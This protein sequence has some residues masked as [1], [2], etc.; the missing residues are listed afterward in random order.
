MASKFFNNLGGNTLFNKF[1]GIAEGMGLN[2]HQFLAV[3]GYFRSS[4]YFKLRAELKDVKKIQILVGINLDNVFRKQK[5]AGLL[6]LTDPKE[7]TKQYTAEFVNDVREA[8]Y[9]KEIEDGILQLCDDLAAGRVEMRIHPTRN[10]HAKFYLCLPEEHSEN[11]DG[12]VIMGSSNISDSGLGTTKTGDQRY[13]LNVAMKEYDDVHYCHEEFLKLWDEGQPIKPTDIDQARK[14]THLGLDPTP[15]QLYMKVLIDAFGEQAEDNFSMAL[16]VG[17]KELK[18][19][20]DAVI[21]GYQMLLRH[22]GFFLADVVGLGKT[23]VAAMIA[24]RFVEANGKQTSILVIYPPAVERNWKDTFREFGLRNRAQFV[25]NGSLSK[26]IEGAGNYRS[27]EEFDLV[28]VDESHNFRNSEND[29][30]DELQRITKAPRQNPG[31]I[32]GSRKKVI[33]ISATAL[34]NDPSDL[35]DQIL[36]FQDARKSTIPELPSLQNYFAPHIAAYKKIMA[37]RKKNPEADVSGVD[38]IYAAIQQDV[39]QKLTVRRTRRNILNDPDYKADLDS[40][41]IVF[42]KITPPSVLKYAMDKSLGELFWDTHAKLTKVMSYARYRAIEF[43]DPEYAKGRFGNAK[44]VAATLAEIYRVH[45][46]K[47]LESSFAAFKGSLKTF[48]R[49]TEDMIKMFKVDKVL[50]IPELNVRELQAKGMEIDAIITYALE[51]LGCEEKDISFPAKA[52]AEGF[53]PMLED[54]L[55]VLMEMEKEWDEVGDDPK[56]DLFIDQLKGPLFNT[57]VNKSGKLVVFSESVDT[58]DYL[59]KELKARLARKD[60]LKVSSANR[61]ALKRTIREN[62][63]ANCPK[64]EFADDYNILLTSDVLSEGI[65]LHRSNMIVNYDSPWNAARLM[66]RIG[67]VNRIGSTADEIHNYMFYPSAEGNQVIG[68]YQ[69]SLLKLQGF[70][71]ALGEDCQIYS[72]EEIVKDFKLFDPTVK[73]EVDDQLKYLRIVREFYAKHRAE[74]HRIKRLPPKCRVVRAAGKGGEMSVAYISSATKAGFYLVQKD[75]ATEIKFLDAARIMAAEPSEKALALKGAYAD[76]HYG[77]VDLALKEFAVA[78]EDAESQD[79]DLAFVTKNTKDAKFLSAQ[80]FLNACDRW[81]AK[82]GLSADFKFTVERL[83]RAVQIGLY[84]HLDRA[85]ADFASGY[86]D[87]KFGTTPD[88]VSCKLIRKTLTDL[89]EKYLSAGLHVQ[90]AESATPPLVVLSETFAS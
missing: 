27:K 70:H 35:R 41:G 13:E 59:E 64:E 7:I 5:S 86:K 14:A 42:P 66:Q 9:T 88:E 26:V 74:Y 24:K 58:L 82:G 73:D 79:D 72:I 3:S 84:T 23:V 56:L 12:W 81:I 68:L 90:A 53:L 15:F 87:V 61:D 38:A 67:R 17:F 65:N 55:K 63:D 8:G 45:M 20:S 10:L 50:V 51:H 34:N 52:F 89:H 31:L 62:F 77:D 69:N 47:R 48:R 21:Q 40:Q 29:R 54:D 2:F 32:G 43:I 44:H 1:K 85:L 71:S 25:T 76:L 6:M 30:Y 33:L 49:I 4:G 60:I 19:Q 57:M 11:S 22:N 37:A 28:I 75:K 18:Y 83:R 46:V 36:L 80:K 39:L 78:A 16:P